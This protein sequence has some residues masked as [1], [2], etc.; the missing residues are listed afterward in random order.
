MEVDRPRVKHHHEISEDLDEEK[1]IQFSRVS[2]GT[3]QIKKKNQ[4]SKWHQGSQ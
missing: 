2:N 3:L 1:N 4:E